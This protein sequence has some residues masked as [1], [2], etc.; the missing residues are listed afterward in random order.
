[1]TARNRLPALLLIALAAGAAQAVCAPEVILLH[2]ERRDGQPAVKSRWLWR[3]ETLAKGAGVEIPGRPEALAWAQALDAPGPYSPV[4][5]PS[6]CPPVE[7]RPDQ[8]FV[9]RVED[10]DVHYDID[11]ASHDGEMLMETPRPPPPAHRAVG[12]LAE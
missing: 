1:M 2:T 3:L 8:L 6:P 7:H 4:K 12:E 9:T 10:P 5:R 11:V